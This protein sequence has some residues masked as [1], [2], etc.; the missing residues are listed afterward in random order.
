MNQRLTLLTSI[1]LLIAFGALAWNWQGIRDHFAL[2][3]FTPTAEIQQ[4]AA[5]DT[6]TQRGKELFFA[7]H[8]E[9]YDRSQ[10]SLHCPRPEAGT[11]V[12][13]CYEEEPFGPGKI[14]LFRI[15]NSVTADEIDVTAAHETLHSAYARLKPWDR[16]KVKSMIDEALATIPDSEKTTVIKDYISQDD[17]N[18]LHSHI[19]TEIEKLPAD[20]EAYYRQY[21]SNRRAVVA[22]HLGNE[23]VFAACNQQ[24]DL[25][26][27][28]LGALKSEL[29]STKEQ[30]ESM[31]RTMDEDLA[32]H[33]ISAYNAL[34]PQ[35]NRLVDQY[36]SLVRRYNSLG[37]SFNKLISRCN[38][39]SRSFDSS[40][41]PISPIQQ[42]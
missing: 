22:I 31:R 13:G 20:L 39:L 5:T 1:V 29:A 15:T 18:E 37:S 33:E 17:Y 24:I 16:Q 3:G 19:G 41:A 10:F 12:L 8:P 21:F 27:A 36:N 4:I 14:A 42:K 6:M 23:A 25:I 40:P 35:Y 9:I 26:Q 11:N 28:Q 30:L 2:S 34:V 32:D 7:A 38:A